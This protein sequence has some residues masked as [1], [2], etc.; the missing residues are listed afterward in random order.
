MYICDKFSIYLTNIQSVKSRITS[1]QSI[2]NT[3]ESDI[4]VINETNLKKNDKLKLEGFKCFSRNRQNA[5][6]G[7]VATCVKDEHSSNTLKVSTGDNEEYI[8][9]RHSQFS[10]AVNVINHYG[11]QESR[12][13]TDEIHSSWE[14]ILNEIPDIEAKGERLIYLGDLNP[15]LG[16]MIKGNN[17]K[18]K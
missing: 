18:T 15:H 17:G 7:G 9:T 1:L 10:P 6:M 16:V 5:A 8:I 13:S 2:V 4:V 12:Q 3:L 14:T 11:T